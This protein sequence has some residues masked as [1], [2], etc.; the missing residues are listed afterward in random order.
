MNV[1][2]LSDFNRFCEIKENLRI[3]KLTNGSTNF[4]TFYS[5]VFRDY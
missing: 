1:K 2:I 4:E 3:N 5:I